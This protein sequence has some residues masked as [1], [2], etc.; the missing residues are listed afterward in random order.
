MLAAKAEFARR[1]INS[2]RLSVATVYDTPLST[3]DED[4][5]KRQ[6]AAR[7]AGAGR[8][9]AQ[10]KPARGIC[11]NSIAGEFT[12]L[13]VKDGAP[14][15]GA[16]RHQARGVGDDIVDADGS[17]AQALRCHARRG[18]SVAAGPASVRALAAL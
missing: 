4:A 13:Y 2:G 1:M 6:R 18:L 12:L 14:A 9:G 3:P 10:R 8:A 16:G 17:F 11:W 15:E 7:R 5:F